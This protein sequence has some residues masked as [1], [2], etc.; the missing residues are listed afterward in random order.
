MCIDYIKLVITILSSPNDDLL[1]QRPQ[2]WPISAPIK[3]HIYLRSDIMVFKS[4]NKIEIL[5]F[6]GF[7]VAVAAYL[8]DLDVHL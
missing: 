2:I 8:I 5:C 7:T 6:W 4:G 3:N 1:D